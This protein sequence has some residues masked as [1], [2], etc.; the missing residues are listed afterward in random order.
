MGIL[1]RARQKLPSTLKRHSV[2]DFCR[3][4]TVCVH[5]RGGSL[6]LAR[7]RLLIITWKKFEEIK[8]KHKLTDIVADREW[9]DQ[10]E[11]S[12]RKRPERRPTLLLSLSLQQAIRH[13][14]LVGQ[15]AT[16]RF[17]ELLLLSNYCSTKY[18]SNIPTVK[19]FSILHAR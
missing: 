3:R 11:S 9:L 15:Q 4:D 16:V 2:C 18:F 14:V 5:S 12:Q 7:R 1:Y 17:V 6:R 10:A 13:F 8:F 19:L